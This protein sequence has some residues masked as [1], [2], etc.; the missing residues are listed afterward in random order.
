MDEKKM[1][2]IQ[3]PDGT[4]MEVEQ[5]TYLIRGDN[6]GAYLVYSKGEKVGEADDEI[7]YISRIIVDGSAYQLEEIVD[8]NEWKEVQD[9]LK[10]IANAQ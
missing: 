9:L 3:N 4:T 7:I 2:V 10:K 5:L 8:D 1:I 6:T